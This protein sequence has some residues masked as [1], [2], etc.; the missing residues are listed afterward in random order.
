MG[1]PIRRTYTAVRLAACTIAAVASAGASASGSIPI[2]SAHSPAPRRRGVTTSTSTGATASIAF[3]HQRLLGSNRPS[4]TSIKSRCNNIIPSISGNTAL[5]NSEGGDNEK[6]FLSTSKASVSIKG[7]TNAGGVSNLS[8]IDQLI[9][10]VTSDQTSLILGSIGIL[11]ILINRLISFPEDAIYEASRSRIDLLGVFAAGSVL[12][13]G[14]TKLDVESVQA[15]RVALEGINQD[16]VVWM[17]KKGDEHNNLLQQLKN[18]EEFKSTVEWALS[19]FLKCSP[20]RTAVLLANANNPSSSSQGSKQWMPIA[21]MG[22]VPIEEELQS[23]IPSGVNTPILD[24]M[25]RTDGSIKGGTVGGT[26]VMGSSSANNKGPKESYLPTLQALPG[27][28]EFT[29]LPSNA[30][31]ALLLPVYNGDKNDNGVGSSWKYAVVLGGDTAKSF[32][33][34]DIAWCKEIASWLIN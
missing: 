22:I 15:E 21:T 30:Q 1:A 17:I 10:T 11:L 3:Q 18:E 34:R 20:A 8:A 19:S 23:A 28:V 2:T 12:L 7:N 13:N 9:L 16:K 26:E 14:I 31:E 32:A 5:F 24:R 4:Y 27:K 33:P 6:S 29:Y 25:L